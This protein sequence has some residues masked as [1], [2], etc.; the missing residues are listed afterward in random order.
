MP[1]SYLQLNA[2][3]Q[4]VLHGRWKRRCM[5]C[6]C[7]GGGERLGAVCVCCQCPSFFCSNIAK[8]L[9]RPAVAASRC[10]ATRAVLYLKVRQLPALPACLPNPPPRPLQKL[11]SA[12]AAEAAAATAEYQRQV[13]GTPSRAHRRGASVD[14]SGQQQQ[15]Q[16]Q[17][18]E[19]M[20]DNIF[21]SYSGRG[22]P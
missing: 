10:A 11:R 18:K 1:T 9:P 12:A 22:L 15:Q 19:D 14:W 16:Q 21:N 8:E 3:F 7:F 13:S 17:S 4:Q 20:L 5:W 6:V 2:L